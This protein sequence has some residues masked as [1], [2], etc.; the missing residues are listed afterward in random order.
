MSIGA[1]SDGAWHVAIIRDTYERGVL[2]NSE[3]ESL[4]HPEGEA[5][6][7][8]NTKMAVDKIIRLEAERIQTEAAARTQDI[9]AAA[10]PNP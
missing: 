10:P 4:S 8:W 9:D 7:R 1:Y 2:V 3:I 5:Q 6:L